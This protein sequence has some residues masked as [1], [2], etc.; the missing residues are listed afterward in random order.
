MNSVQQNISDWSDSNPATVA[1]IL[2]NGVSPSRDWPPHLN[3]AVDN[4]YHE[5]EKEEDHPIHDSF[6]D[7][8]RYARESNKVEMEAYEEQQRNGCCGSFDSRIEVGEE[9]ILIGWNYGH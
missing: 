9:A 4:A 1:S 3:A 7:N 6:C 8:F 5:W 2:K